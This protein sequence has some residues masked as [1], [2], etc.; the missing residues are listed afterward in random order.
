MSKT[1]RSEMEDALLNPQNGFTCIP[2]SSESTP[3]T[4]ASAV[5]RSPSPVEAVRKSQIHL[6]L[7]DRRFVP[8]RRCAVDL[9]VPV[10]LGAGPHN[11]HSVS[12]SEVLSRLQD[13]LSV[14]RAPAILSCP[15]YM[16]PNYPQYF[17]Q[18]ADGRLEDCAFN[19]SL[20][21]L[22][23]ENK[24]IVYVD[25]IQIPAEYLTG[26]Y[27][28][29]ASS[30]VIDLHTSDF[31]TEWLKEQLAAMPTYTRFQEHQ[32]RRRLQNSD[33]LEDWNFASSF[34][35]RYYKSMCNVTKKSITCLAI[36]AALGIASRLAVVHGSGGSHESADV[37]QELR[38]VRDPPL[39]KGA[40]L[41]FL[42]N[43]E[44]SHS[45]T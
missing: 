10:T 22:S 13:T 41:Y 40:L 24:L 14:I 1:R 27:H 5:L 2:P 15:H 19:P 33:I 37:V 7:Q 36:Q 42:E 39:G 44:A 29:Q 4:P 25:K 30:D 35:H 8:S 34:Y 16:D 31:T 17:A 11:R 32:R 6:F 9:E 20:L 21:Y 3:S 23:G 26:T 38:A 18:W 43:W 12:A 45:S 28:L